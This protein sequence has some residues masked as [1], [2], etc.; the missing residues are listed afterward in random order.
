MISEIRLQEGQKGK[1]QV[2]L[3]HQIFCSFFFI[4]LHYSVKEFLYSKF[5]N[6]SRLGF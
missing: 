5:F 4:L 2:E 6:M 1:L 3:N